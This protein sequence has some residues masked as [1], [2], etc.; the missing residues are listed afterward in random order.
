MKIYYD[1]QT[2]LDQHIGGISRYFYEMVLEMEKKP[3]CSVM[4]RCVGGK[5]IYIKA[6]NQG[7]YA[8]FL[9]RIG[10][11]LPIKK[12]LGRLNQLVMKWDMH[13]NYD[14]VHPTLYN[15]YVLEHTGKAKV[16][17]TIYD[18]IYE[19]FP[20]LFPE[21]KRTEKKNI[22]FKADHIIAISES[23]K[24][25]ILRF[26]PEI[27]ESKVSVV[28]LATNM[29][30]E[31]DP[32]L[33]AKLPE[34]YVLYVGTRSGYK[35]FLNFVKAMHPI[36]EADK[37]LQVVCTGGG[38]FKAEEIECMAEY[39][40][41]FHQMNCDERLLAAAYSNAECLVYPTMYE[42]FGFP[43]LEALACECPAVVSNT[44]S[45]P[46]VGGDAARYFDPYNVEDMTTQIYAVLS[47]SDLRQEMIQKGSVQAQKFDWAKIT[48]D[49]L[50]CYHKILNEKK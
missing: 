33:R 40:D 17:I 28:Y 14:I 18:M 38:I 49:T 46:E 37:T 10:Q 12:G 2:F 3:E 23:T 29:H 22:A 7:D 6:H 47:D 1:Y 5:N 25:D 9:N 31:D 19:Q 26:Y 11:H 41:R 44:S 20:E 36:L 34:Q 4:M 50:D 35:N 24:R 43:T 39:A 16:V 21:G 15:P 30:K 48:Q 42:G 27:E 45:I 13:R 32:V 8:P